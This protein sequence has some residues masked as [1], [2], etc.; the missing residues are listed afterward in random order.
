MEIII[1]NP[2]IDVR[3]T[4]AQESS[5]RCN[6][7]CDTKNSSAAKPKSLNVIGVK[8]SFI[9]VFDFA[10][11]LKRVQANRLKRTKK[12]KTDMLAYIY[13]LLTIF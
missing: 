5:K 4:I 2:A 1:T 10:G 13:Y 11:I 6:S 8:N 9:C 3:R 7:R 12:I